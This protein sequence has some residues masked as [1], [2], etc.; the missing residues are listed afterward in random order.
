MP[1]LA[2]EHFCPDVVT[3]NPPRAGIYRAVIRQ[4]CDLNPARI[5]YISCQ[6]ET[7]VRDLVQFVKAGYRIG[8][9]QPVDLFPQTPH[10]EVVVKLEKSPE[11]I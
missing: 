9:V 3:I 2:K 1:E 5:V 4:I 11:H 8:L 7:L 10:V 6:P